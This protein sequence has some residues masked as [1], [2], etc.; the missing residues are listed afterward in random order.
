M[1][2][3]LWLSTH[4]DGDHISSI[5]HPYTG[6]AEFSSSHLFLVVCDHDIGVQCY[7]NGFLCLIIP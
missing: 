7:L 4:T 1:P 6:C 3:R 2:K 5:H